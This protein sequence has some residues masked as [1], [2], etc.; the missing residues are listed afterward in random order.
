MRKLLNRCHAITVSAALTLLSSPAFAHVVL[1]QK[2]AEAGSYYKATLR[3][4]H[5][6]KGSPTTAIQVMLPEGF[7]SAKPMPKPGWT[8]TAPKVKLAQSYES[9]GKTISEDVNTITWS[10]GPLPDGFYDEFVLFGKLPGK[11]GTVHFKVL[12][13]CESGSNPWTEI[14][15]PGLKAEFPAAALELTAPKPSEH[16]GH[17]H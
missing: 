6:C 17:K 14:P 2:T 15:A 13:Q 11:P 3:V 12:Q 9:H 7:R 4:G 16:T 10:G 1:E 5:G 8:I